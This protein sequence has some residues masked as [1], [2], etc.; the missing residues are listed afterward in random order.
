MMGAHVSF[1]IMAGRPRSPYRPGMGTDPPY[2]GAR[3]PQLRLDR[4][5]TAIGGAYHGCTAHAPDLL[6]AT[7]NATRYLIEWLCREAHLGAEDAYVLSSVVAELRIS[8]VVDA[9]N[10]T[11]TP[12]SRW[13]CSSTTSTGVLGHGRGR[14]ARIRS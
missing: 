10:W 7:R 1:R 5:P 9:P 4:P 2:L 8:Q 3:E 12:S 13:R 14:G 11:V 6:E